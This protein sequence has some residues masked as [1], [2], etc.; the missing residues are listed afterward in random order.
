MVAPGTLYIDVGGVQASL[1]A[2]R[3]PQLSPLIRPPDDLLPLAHS[4]DIAAMKL[5]AI[6]SRGSRKDFVDLWFLIHEQPPLQRCLDLFRRKYDSRDIGHVVRSLTYFD[7]ANTEPELR[8]LVEAP[9][10]EIKIDF[11][12][13]VGELLGG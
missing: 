3:Y 1:F 7:D 11:L 4:D 13:W 6:T 12:R 9:W 2:Y 10:D 5:A 8:M